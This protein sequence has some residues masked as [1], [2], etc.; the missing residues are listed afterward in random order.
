MPSSIYKK[1]SKVKDYYTK[2]CLIG[3]SVGIV[4]GGVIGITATAASPAIVGYYA[5]KAIANRLTTT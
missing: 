4:V 3:L 5:I 1:L 2:A